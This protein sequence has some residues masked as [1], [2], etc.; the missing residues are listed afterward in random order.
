MT[1]PLV[2]VATNVLLHCVD[3]RE[4]AKRDRARA[5]V[6]ACWR[7]HCGRLS[8]QVLNDYYWSATR[9]FPTAVARGDARADVRRYQHW[10]PWQI[11][12]A[13]IETAWAAEARHQLNYWDA[14]MVASAQQQGCTLLL[15][16]ELPHDQLIDS[17]RILDP[18]VVGP[19]ILDTPAP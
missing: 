4:P 11:D 10:Q 2:F 13:T 1:S 3:D 5:W 7:R 12:H 17:V 14:L 9:R 16:D 6:S 19:E 8:T 18:F 15:T